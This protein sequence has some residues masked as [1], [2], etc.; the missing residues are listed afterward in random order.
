MTIHLGRQVG[1]FEALGED[2]GA[3]MRRAFPLRLGLSLLFGSSGMQLALVIRWSSGFWYLLGGG[4]SG[5]LIEK[6]SDGRFYASEGRRIRALVHDML[7]FVEG[8]KIISIFA[9]CCQV[10][11]DAGAVEDCGLLRRQLPHGQL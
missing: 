1:A 9:F 4:L 6:V 10:V 2:G 11:A 5:I 7:Q 3:L 8:P